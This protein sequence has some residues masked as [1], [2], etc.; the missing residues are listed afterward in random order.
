MITLSIINMFLKVKYADSGDSQHYQGSRVQGARGSCDHGI[1][2]VFH[3]TD[4]NSYSISY[5]L[6]RKRWE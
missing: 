3:G 2:K 4:D 1:N 5:A 6:R